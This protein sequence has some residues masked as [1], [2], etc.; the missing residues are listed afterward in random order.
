MMSK[1]SNKASLVILSKFDMIIIRYAK[2]I[3]NTLVLIAREVAAEI[4]IEIAI[5]SLV[6]RVVI[7]IIERKIRK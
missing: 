5:T 3:I 7:I 4:I 1:S 6:I 2:T